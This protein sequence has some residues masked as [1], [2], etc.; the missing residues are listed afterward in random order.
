MFSQE[1][2]DVPV[3][4]PPSPTA[5]ELGKFGQIPIGMFTGTPNISI[6]I[7]TYKTTNISVPI[8]LS[9]S[10]NGIKVD[11]LSSN[12]G[13]GWNLNVGGVISRTARDGSDENRN[14]IFPEEDIHQAGV[15][16]PMALDYFNLG[17]QNDV[18][19]ET[20]LF[21]Y[22]FMGFSGSF[23]LDKD[24]QVVL[25]PQKDLTISNYLENGV[26]GFKIITS[27]GLTYIFLDTEVNGNKISGG[28]VHP[29]PEYITTAWYLSK[30]I[31][32]KGDI[33][34]FLYDAMGYFY[35]LNKSQS[36][37]VA[38]PTY[39]N[40]CPGNT[41]TGPSYTENPVITNK[42][43]VGGKRL[44]K[45]QSNV[46]AA[47]TV[48]F[49]SNISHPVASAYKL[50]SNISVKNEA[51]SVIES[52]DFNYLLTNNN[53]VFLQ[54]ITFKDTSKFYT[55]D[56]EDPQGLVSRLSAAQDF[57][58]YYNG[59]TSNTKYYPN[60]SSLG[61]SIPN[62]LSI[63]NIG[64]D[65]SVDP[66][67]AVKGLLKKVTYPTKGYTELTYEPNS[68]WSE[69]TIYPS[70]QQLS[71]S[72][73]TGEFEMGSAYDTIGSIPV[74]PF[75]Q[76]ASLTAYAS[77]NSYECSEDLLKSQASITVKDDQTGN[78]I[79]ILQ[80]SQSGYYPIGTSLLVKY[81]STNNQY[82]VDLVS[83]HSY[84]VTL[85]PTYSCTVASLTLDYYDEPTSNQFTNLISGGMRIKDVKSFTAIGGTPEITRYYYGKK[86][87]PD[88]SSGERELVGYYLSNST[89]RIRCDLNCSYV[90]QFFTTLN[91]NSLRPLFNST[92]NGTTYYKY[93]TVSHGGNN[94]ENGGE[95]NEYLIMDDFP[96][97]PLKGDYIQSAP[98]VNTGW[99]NGLLKKNT[100]FKKDTS[101]DFITLN[102]TINNYIE[103]NRLFSKVYGY[104]INKKFDLICTADITY[105]CTSEDLTK[106]YEYVQCDA[107]HSHNWLLGGLPFGLGVDG[108]RHKTVCIASGH[109]NN[110]Y[111]LSHPC[112]GKYVGYV[113]T[114]P[115][116]LENLDITEYSTNSYWYYLNQ[117]IENK[118]DQDGL[119]PV[120]T[121][122]NYYYDN[123]DHKQVTRTE[124]I[125]SDT[126]KKVQTNTYYPDDVESISS[127][128]FDDLSTYEKSAIDLLKT[129]S[130]TNADAQYRIAE[131]IQVVT[132]VKDTLGNELSNS[133]MRTN[134]KDWGNNIVS[135]QF[136]QSLKG[137]YNAS[138]N[139]LQDRIEFVKYYSNGN[140]KEVSK[141][142][143]T[144]VVYIW[145][146][147]SQ[148]PIAKIENATYAEVAAALGVSETTLDTY[149]EANLTAINGLRDNNSYS[150]FM[151][152]S[153][154][155]TPLVGVTSTTDPKGYTTN[156]EYD[157]FNR[158]KSVKD[159]AGKILNNYNYHYKN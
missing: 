78:N 1:N 159:A 88:E 123:P 52:Y 11:Q 96:G 157:Q 62:E 106:R 51:T 113:V 32:P 16:S 34:E 115:D 42:L 127:L 30:I 9:Y 130:D 37:T 8:Y 46:P 25:V 39:Q 147:D 17:G 18:D 152:T 112:Y 56:Y 74:L 47:G 21:S 93:V 73:S 136:V 98:W 126:N 58:G 27:D 144:P 109:D 151:V 105:D 82:Y 158:L 5:Y 139:T 6:P 38:T 149:D 129:P 156:F 57:W 65:K 114:R 138:N 99:G 76:R 22:N 135:P 110:I 89:N 140:I 148:Y 3:Y 33:V 154:T 104:N 14:V 60:P 43:T 79:N 116:M 128:G 13:L 45:I 118:Y 26:S 28:V 108:I 107:N 49:T 80:R 15:N 125:T 101:G 94:F 48:D 91:S 97:N 85:H 31:S 77:F 70:K 72:T 153:F 75:N 54:Q 87:F 19:T 84:T 20:D 50:I 29:E 122:T 12:V 23:V 103:D 68:Y 142:D 141:K 155:Y 61:P 4:T 7:Y 134:Y 53:R 63:W 117:K 146:Y 24:K 36:I 44:T 86:E 132:K 119:N 55:F 40:G 120:A 100:V 145:G 64:A 10:S 121:I 66:T 131:P 133:V 59:K 41:G 67:Y 2:Y 69:E 95:E 81:N 71:L 111:Y 83:G 102:E 90:D 124:V 35:D 137:V 92:N 143:G 150:K